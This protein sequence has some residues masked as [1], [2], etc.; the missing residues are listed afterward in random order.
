MNQ[1][2]VSSAREREEDVQ[3]AAQPNAEQL[4]DAGE[5]VARALLGHATQ[6]VQSMAQYLA[7]VSPQA[8]LDDARELARS[9][10][11]LALGGAFL[12]GALAVRTLEN[13]RRDQGS[14]RPTVD[15]KGPPERER[16]AGH[17]PAASRDRPAP[18]SAPDADKPSWPSADPV[19]PLHDPAVVTGVGSP[20]GD[21]PYAGGSSH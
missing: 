20:I 17:E 15:G 7:S 9:Q 13:P 14:A 10:P 2:H 5:R 18:R 21:A 6:G 11:V 3:D 8:L 12:L 4:S 1:Q 19:A 16:K